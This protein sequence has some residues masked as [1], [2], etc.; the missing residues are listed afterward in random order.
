MGFC[1]FGPDDVV[2]AEANAHLDGLVK[3]W[4]HEAREAG[5]SSD[6]MARL[7]TRSFT[8]SRQTASP[9]W[10]SVVHRNVTV[11]CRGLE[12]EGVI[13]RISLS[14]CKMSPGRVG[15]GHAISPPKPII[16]LANGGPPVTRSR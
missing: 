11:P 14:T 13:S 2:G 1:W 10:F 5:A 8:V 16:P 4:N 6:Q 12:R 3:T 15:L 7:K 9:F